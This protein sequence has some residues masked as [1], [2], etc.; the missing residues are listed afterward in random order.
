MEKQLEQNKREKPISVFASALLTG[1]IGGVIWSFF[2]VVAA[3][4]NF[5]SVSPASFVFR[6][7]LQTNWS[8]GWLGQ[9]L[10]ILVIGLLS[11]LVAL[12]YYLLFKQLKGIWTSIM[13]GIALWFVVFY[14]LQPIFPNI[15]HMTKLDSNT[16]VTTL[17]LFGLYGAFIGYSISYE[18]QDSVS[19]ENS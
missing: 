17:C 13:F 2:G 8:D 18:Y 9:L 19:K 4:F 5:S 6:S 12:A 11:I 16:I 10:S 7:W 14:L 1:F 3:Y 15:N